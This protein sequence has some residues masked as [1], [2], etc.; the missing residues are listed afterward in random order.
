MKY[1]IVTLYGNMKDPD[2]FY[3]FYRNEMVPRILSLD[4]VE[5]ICVNILSD[6]PI[7]PSPQNSQGHSVM[8]EL[9]VKD[10]EKFMKSFQESEAGQMI[11]HFLAKEAKDV[12][13]LYLAIEETIEKSSLEIEKN[14][15]AD[16]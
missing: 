3:F 10:V 16:S 11:T 15:V 9:Y 2:A 4:G 5:K 7:S 8:G 1:K 14:E 6:S 13:T 12:S